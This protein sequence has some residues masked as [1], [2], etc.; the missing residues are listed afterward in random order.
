MVPAT[1]F[2]AS[3]IRISIRKLHVMALGRANSW[4]HVALHR[5]TRH[6]FS[7]SRTGT[8][9]IDLSAEEH[10][11]R[12]GRTG[13]REQSSRQLV[14]KSCGKLL[15]SVVPKM[16][17]H[18]SNL[19]LC[20]GSGTWGSRERRLTCRRPHVKAAASADLTPAARKMVPE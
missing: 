9:K 15:T 12:S 19:N 14:R 18:R 1:A 11:L 7:R 17:L 3:S 20:P 10:C 4:T 2:L 8:R 16:L 5:S 6:T 13:Q